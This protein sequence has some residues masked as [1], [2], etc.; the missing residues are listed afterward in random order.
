MNEPTLNN[1]ANPD[2]PHFDDERTVQS[3]RPVV[4]LEQINAKVRHR[5]Q[6]LLGGAFAIA[7]MLGAASALVAS[8][9]KLRN[10][11]TPV[12][13]V[14]VTSEPVAVA[15]DAP[16][17]I[18]EEPPVQVPVETPT[19][20]AAPPK[21]RTVAKQIDELYRPSPTRKASEEEDLDRIREA[22]LYDEWQERRA[23]RA[24]RRERRRLDR[25]NHRDLSNLDEIFEGRRRRVNPY[26]D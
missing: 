13:E 7:M 17:A 8:Y 24:E 11:A 12:A 14:E 26:P 1:S 15:E 5:R 3:A 21:P 2:L 23:R 6:W 10:T 25:Y 22:V 4:P 19:P 18:V 9:L 20:P 16:A